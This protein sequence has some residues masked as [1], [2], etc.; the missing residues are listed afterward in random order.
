MTREEDDAARADGSA[1]SD[2]ARPGRSDREETGPDQRWAQPADEPRCPVHGIRREKHRVVVGSYEAARRFL[3]LGRASTQAGFTAERIPDRLFRRRPLLISD[4]QLHDRQRRELARFFAPSTIDSEYTATIDARAEE[5]AKGLAERGRIRL[6]EESLLF[7][8]EI[9]ARI[10]GLTASST[11]GL[12]RRLELFFDQPH[13][14]YSR[15]DLGRSR[16][17]WAL[18]AFRGL[19][20]VAALY[21]CDVAP[22]MR[23]HRRDPES[24]VMGYL[25]DSGASRVDILVECMTY[26]TAGMV[27]TRE[28]MGMACWHLMR[29]PELCSRYRAAE[30]PDREGILREIIRLEPV[31]G[32]VYRRV[33]DAEANSSE[34]EPGDLIDVDVRAV[35]TDPELTGTC[36]MRL[37][38]DRKAG[39][40]RA[41]GLSF[42]A[43]PHKCPGENLAIRETDALLTRLLAL[44][45]RIVSEPEIEWDSVIAGYR[46]RGFVLDVDGTGPPPKSS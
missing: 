22:A 39:R 25:M 38:P 24:D 32:H 14:D 3:R 2:A 29:D 19:R 26:G 35:N 4:G 5:L 6:D 1:R 15:P 30:R 46:L 21:V 10:V 37:D 27:T 7:S 23:K 33:G 8:V 16:T 45:P 13:A 41:A 9:A 44:N 31:V 28:F 18:A 20:A 34:F 12:A 43:G 36:P 42:G 40:A 17:D 11:R